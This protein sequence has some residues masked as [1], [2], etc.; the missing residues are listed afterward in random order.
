V[1]LRGVQACGALTHAPFWPVFSRSFL[2]RAQAATE[3]AEL[4]AKRAASPS[5][6]PGPPG[7]KQP[8]PAALEDDPAREAFERDLTAFYASKAGRE[9]VALVEGATREWRN[10]TMCHVVFPLQALWLRVS[11]EG[12]YDAVCRRKLWRRIAD[13]FGTFTDSNNIAS[14]VSPWWRKRACALAC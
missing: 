4:R 11:E 14:K 12:G 8:R 9:A 3:A 7:A 2:P 6:P 1:L 10:P 5:G 13:S